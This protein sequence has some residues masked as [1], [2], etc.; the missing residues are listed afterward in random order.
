MLDVFVPKVYQSLVYLSG[1]S[2]LLSGGFLEP[3]GLVLYLSGD[4]GLVAVGVFQ[5]VR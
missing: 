2:S 5:Q 4:P 3:K 1:Q